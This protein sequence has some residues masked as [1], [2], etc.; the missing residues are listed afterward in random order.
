MNTELPPLEPPP[1]PAELGRWLTKPEAAEFFGKSERTIRHW[2]DCGKLHGYQEPG[3]GFVTWRIWSIEGEKGPAESLRICTEPETSASE[4]LPA[5]VP[6]LADV[7]TIAREQ[8]SELLARH[9]LACRRI[10]A[11]E[12]VL[13]D[14]LP[15]LEDGQRTDRESVAILA[16]EVAMLATAV[17][18]LAATGE[19]ERR[20]VGR[21]L[22][23]VAV[24]LMVLAVLLAAVGGMV[25]SRHGPGIANTSHSSRMPASLSTAPRATPEATSPPSRTVST[26]ARPSAGRP[27]AGAARSGG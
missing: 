25:L 6:P 22:R 13:R 4:P 1:P 24:A 26:D 3:K 27:S 8:F 12:E 9:E 10:G 14:R 18:E 17:P 20:R 5:L 15:A 11:L 2:L 19:G 16:G 23:G 21:R 7:V